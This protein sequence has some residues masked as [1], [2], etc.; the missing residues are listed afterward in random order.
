MILDGFIFHLAAQP[1]KDSFKRLLT[2][3]VNAIGTANLASMR[4]YQSNAFWF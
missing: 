2:H 1:R 4:N 3:H